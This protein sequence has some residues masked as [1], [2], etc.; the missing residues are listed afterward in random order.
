MSRLVKVGLIGAG[1]TTLIAVIVFFLS[2]SS[3]K[4]IAAFYMPWA[5]LLLIGLTQRRT[6]K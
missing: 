1:I 5:V 6:K 2:P 4:A 3:A